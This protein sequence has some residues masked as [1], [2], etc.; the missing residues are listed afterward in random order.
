MLYL[1]SKFIP[2]P[3]RSTYHVLAGPRAGQRVTTTWWQWRDR[4]WSVHTV[5]VLPTH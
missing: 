3:M 1:L 5:P 2:V 4:V